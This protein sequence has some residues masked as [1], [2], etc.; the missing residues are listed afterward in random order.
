MKLVAF[1]VWLGCILTKMYTNEAKYK[2]CLYYKF[3]V[4]IKV[5]ILKFHKL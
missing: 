2:F 3:D 4:E 1:K 5:T